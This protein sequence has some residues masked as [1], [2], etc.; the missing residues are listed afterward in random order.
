MMK[1]YAKTE[2]LK[3]LQRALDV[4]AHG[5]MQHDVWSRKAHMMNMQGLKRWHKLQSE[6]DRCSRVELQ[7]YIID[8]F[9]VNLEP[10][11]D[12]KEIES[13]T[14]EKLV[15]DYLSWEVSVYSELAN[16]SNALMLLEMPCEATI[17]A[18]PLKEVRK[19]IE[20]ARRMLADYEYVNWDKAYI[21]LQDKKLHDK[22]K[23]IEG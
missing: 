2:G 14:L 19:E 1:D 17:V 9:G 10:K 4:F 18:A 16:V 12:Y 8:M 21:K 20:K 13:D 15:T 11:W 7:H 22:V 5:E 3:L 6:D 23:D